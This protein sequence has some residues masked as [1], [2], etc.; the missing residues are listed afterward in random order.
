MMNEEQD[1]LA[2]ES[3]RGKVSELILDFKKCSP[4]R[5]GW[6]RLD[7]NAQ[8]RDAVWTG[9]SADGKKHALDATTPAFPWEGAS[10]ARVFVA[11]DIC[12]ENVALCVIGFFRAMIRFAGVEAKDG[13]EAGD[14]TRFMERL[15]EGPGFADLL[16]EVELSAQLM[17]EIGVFVLHPT[18]EREVGMELKEIRMRELAQAAGLGGE[19]LRT[20]GGGLSGGAS[21]GAYAAG[22]NGSL[23]PTSGGGAQG[24]PTAMKLI[25]LVMDPAREEE[26]I[27][28]VR[29]VGKEI[30]QM[31]LGEFLESVECAGLEGWELSVARARDFVRG[32]REEGYGCV[33]VPVVMRNEA[34][35]VALRPWDEVFFRS[36]AVDLGRQGRVYRREFMDVV[37][38]RRRGR[39]EGWDSAWM[40]AV[41][42]TKGKVSEWAG[43]TFGTGTGARDW[44]SDGCWESGSD[45]EDLVEVLYGFQR[46]VDSDG[47]LSYWVTVFSAHASSG[48][49]KEAS[50]ENDF[51]GKHEQVSS[52]EIQF[53]MGLRERRGRGVQRVRGVPELVA[54]RQREMK[55]H[56]DSLVDLASMAVIPPINVM[57]N[58]AK[59]RY[60]FG[61][62][63]QN[64]VQVGM[65]PKF[66]EVPTKGAPLAIEALNRLER[67]LDIEHGRAREDVPG[68]RTMAKQ[69]MLLNSFLGAWSVGLQGLWRLAL[70]FTGAAEY[71]RITGG[72][73]PQGTPARR[74]EDLILHFDV[75]DLDLEHVQAIYAA[76][77]DL[78]TMDAG[79]V[80]DKGKLVNVMARMINPSVAREVIIPGQG[81][82]QQVFRQV[83]NDLVSMLAGMEPEYGED[84]DPT[85][86][87]KLGFV[88]QIVKSS[89]K[90][91]QALENDGDFQG[92]AQ[93]YLESLQFNQS[94]QENKVVGRIGVTREQGQ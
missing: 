27:E 77:K 14:A 44:T 9:Q 16:A 11:D 23:H 80:L 60:R 12:N 93:K 39:L 62:G 58:A 49:G 43:N 19:G 88:D 15:M 55:A 81:A 47:V 64:I 65:E 21:G 46:C 63:V 75:R 13:E 31:E 90:L 54:S 59:T 34:T 89:P 74:G 17:Q 5:G 72:P 79:G 86:G 84:A 6:N 32:L 18:M 82:S 8:T 10:D 45:F 73:K 35:V 4:W 24:N 51:C 37:E 87:M 52:D 33:P 71:E 69:Q 28:F 3:G 2:V 61:P 26:A 38:F 29:E 70:K 85:A 78:V 91:Q 66:A 7:W 67:E 56:R 92:R 22:G 42:K 1:G 50:G 30:V 40:E 76:F 41:E 68:T 53:V 57:L 94:Q 83:K 36:Y 20:E 25:E 48:E